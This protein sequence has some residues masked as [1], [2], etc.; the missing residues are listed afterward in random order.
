MATSVP[1]NSRETRRRL[2]DSLRLDLVGPDNAHPCAQETLAE[3]PRQWY[4]SGYL[5]PVSAPPEEKA[6]PDQ[7][8]EDDDGVPTGSGDEPDNAPDTREA[9]KSLLP[10]SIGL[11]VLVQPESRF[12]IT[13]RWGDYHAD[14][15][16]E[17]VQLDEQGQA[18]A[19]ARQ[20]R[21]APGEGW[22]EVAFG[23]FIPD[24]P[25]EDFPELDGQGLRIIAVLRPLHESSTLDLPVGTHALSVFLVNQRHAPYS[26]YQGNAF[27]VELEIKSSR[28]FVAQPDLRG[29][30]HADAMDWDERLADLQYRDMH[31]FA[32]GHGISTESI[33]E[34][35]GDCRRVRTTWIPEHEVERV[36]PN[37]AIDGVEFGLTALGQT[38]EPKALQ[39]SLQPLVDLYR[40]WIVLQN[41]TIGSLSGK[42]QATAQDS[43]AHASRAACRIETGIRMIVENGDAFHA[44]RIANRAMAQAGARRM[45]RAPSD[46]KWRPFQLAFILMNLPGLIDETHEDREIVDL[47]FFP[48]GGGKTEAYLGLAAF[49]MVLRRRKH[50][51]I[52]YAGL[53]VL[54]RYTLRLLTLDQLGRAAGLVCALELEREKD[55]SLGKLPF[56]IGLWVGSSVVP[57]TLGGQGYNGSDAEYTAYRKVSQFRADT[58][59]PSPIPIEQCPWCGE[60][61]GGNSFRFLPKES[62]PNAK[63]LRIRC[64]NLECEFNGTQRYLPLQT[65]DE[66]IYRRLPAFLIATVDKFAALPWSPHVGALFGHVHRYDEHGFYGSGSPGQ[67]RSS[68]DSPLPGVDLIIQ[69][70][71]HLISGPLGTVAGVYETA[72]ESLASRSKGGGMIRPKIVASTATV[73]QASQQIRALFGREESAIFP[74]QGPDLRDTF[75]S[76]TKPVL[77]TNGRLYLGIAAQGRS[78]KVILMRVALA[79]L[80]SAQKLYNEAGGKI[81]NN[82]ADPYMTLLGYFNSLRE[83]GGSRRIMEDEVVSR[84]RDRGSR[85]RIAPALIEFANRDVAY[86]PEELTS[87]VSTA[88]V[89][90]AKR[91]LSLCFDD[92]M[93]GGDRPIDVALATNMISVGL[94]IDRLGLMLVMGQPKGTAEYIQA[95]SRVGRNDDKPG[96]VIT[97]LNIHRPRDRSH[98][99]HFRMYHQTF[100][101][102]VEAS[103]ITPFSPRALDRALAASLVGLARHAEPQL[104]AN[105]HAKQIAFKRGELERLAV[106]F[107][108]RAR[109]HRNMLPSESGPLHDRVLQ[110]CRQLLDDWSKIE[111]T[112]SSVG[113]GLKYTSAAPCLIH[114]FLEETL[115]TPSALYENFRANRS[116]RTVEPTVELFA[117]DLDE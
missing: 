77:E 96:L 20:F 87:R 93:H 95:T 66:C 76:I 44:F 82:P 1:P 22:I 5:V 46:L 42:R 48:T 89:A 65:I 108:E 38:E 84:A 35:N 80:C 102:S 4:L 78:M 28:P 56:E 71:L 85:R 26:C 10:S 116:M 60:K 105:D 58:T 100:Y 24:V 83:L 88:Q 40:T 63:D 94:D 55:A 49:A 98:Y 111:Q 32:V 113:V 14:S 2:V 54:M 81:K 62:Y 17:E 68:V 33:I 72:L 110:L 92:P 57:N 91:L 99:E 41:G 69:D 34:E 36:A 70:E 3:S 9:L 50:P 79:L 59:R 53:S 112:V 31:D 6:S 86:E 43:L 74:P 39:T 29:L 15:S 73:R 21:R 109:L 51:G 117:K 19:V 7:I 90:R 12:T 30:G 45:K 103:S 107:A 75:F 16:H 104:T 27:Q 37:L 25:K 64:E 52:R 23:D 97:L 18:T 101:R 13:A 8:E 106:T 67:G 114:D 115:P 47:L 11:T 61:F